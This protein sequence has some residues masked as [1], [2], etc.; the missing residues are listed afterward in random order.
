[1]PVLPSDLAATLVARR[2]VANARELERAD[3]LRARVREVASRLRARG[4]VDAAWLVGS[5]AWGRFGPRSD[6]DLVVRGTD[7][8]RLG[9]L[10]A[11]VVEQLGPDAGE[12]VD[13]LRFEELAEPFRRRV[14][15]EGQRLDEP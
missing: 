10:W 5:L 4:V 7:P 15:S 12:Q 14:L 3:R 8:S 9:A 2:Q 13:L 11:D 1:M 6:V